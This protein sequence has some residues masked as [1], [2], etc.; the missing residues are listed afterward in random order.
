MQTRETNWSGNYVYEALELLRPR[1]LAELAEIVVDAEQVRALGSRHS[2]TDLAD[3]PGT[4]VSLGDLPQDVEIDG[5]A[6]VVRVSAGVTYAHLSTELY[7]AGWALGGMASLPHITVAGA[8]A[9]GTHGSGD[10]V[11]SLASAVRAVE[12]L[13]ADGRPR[14]IG[15]GESGF[16]GQVV[17][18]GALGVVT[19]LTLDVE[20]TFQVRQDVHLALGWDDLV[21]KFDAIMGS[22]Y[23]VSVFTDWVRSER[24]QVWVK[25]RVQPD[26]G[27]FVDPLGALD[28]S[29][30]SPAVAM[31]HMLRGAPEEALTAQ[32]G[33]PGP[34]HERLPHFRME[35]T[36]SRGAELQSEYFVPRRHAAAAVAALHEAGPGF[37]DQLQVGEIRTIAGDQLWLSGAYGEDTVAFHFTWLLDPPAVYA[38]LPVIEAALR[39][40][41]GRPHWG[42]C[43]TVEAPELREVY[44]RLVDFATLRDDLD[45]DRKFGNGFLERYLV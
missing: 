43:F 15:R 14:T 31:T 32:L 35:F 28:L 24:N 1:S 22:A 18:L 7:R 16:D 33:E 3:S 17:S 37:A 38:V 12:T 30:L 40:F 41:G 42:K 39:P 11:G 21:E 27:T 29:G 4:L 8:V 6:G 13:G 5:E 23:S 19:H 2:F 44:P 26:G 45:P 36:P 25:S 20:P 10:R 9:T 34:W